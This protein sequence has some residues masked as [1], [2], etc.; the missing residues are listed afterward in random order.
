MSP[1]QRDE[2]AFILAEET[3]PLYARIEELEAELK[4]AQEQ[5]A[6]LGEDLAVAEEHK[7]DTEDMIAD[8]YSRGLTDGAAELEAKITAVEAEQVDV[9]ADAYDRGR[10][11]GIAE[12]EPMRKVQ[13]ALH[14]LIEGS[15]TAQYHAPSNTLH[16][17]RATFA[18]LGDNTILRALHDAALAFTGEAT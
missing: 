8:A 6:E 16:L 12:L 14:K 1:A 7:E 3:R 9:A 17:G 4:N 10:A 11:D 15:D 13:E 18:A 2:A 5:L